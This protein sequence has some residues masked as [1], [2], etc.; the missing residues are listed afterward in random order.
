MNPRRSFAFA[1]A[2]AAVAL[3][4]RAVIIKTFTVNSTADVV[5][6]NPGDGLCETVAGNH[7]CTLRAAVR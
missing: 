6:V 1:V 4:A 7:T 5:D 3:P 2:L